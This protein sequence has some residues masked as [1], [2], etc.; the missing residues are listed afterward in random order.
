ML[1]AFIENLAQRLPISSERSTAPCY[2]QNFAESRAPTVATPS[3]P[4]SPHSQANKPEMR[5]TSDLLE[6]LQR[7]LSQ[8][9][10]AGF[11]SNLLTAPSASPS[12][13]RA[14]ELPKP[15]D[16][17]KPAQTT[18]QEKLFSV[19]VEIEQAVNLPKLNVSKKYGKRNK[20][21]AGGQQQRI[22][23]E[24]SA[25][26]TFEGYNL[27][28]GTA[29]TVKS[30]EG[31][32]YTTAVV[33][34]SCNPAWGK[35]FAVQLPV[36]LMTNDEKR[37]IL[38]VWRKAVSAGGDATKT[39]SQRGQQQPAPMEDAV[40]GFTAV[41]LS[42]LL[43]GMPCIMGW[44]NIMDFSGRCNGQIKVSHIQPQENV[45][46]TDDAHFRSAVDRRR[47]R[48]HRRTGNTSLSRAL[49]RKIYRTR[50]NLPRL[51]A[52]LF[53]VTGS[54]DNDDPDDEFERDLNTEAEEGDDG[55]WVDPLED[56]FSGQK[57]NSQHPNGEAA[58]TLTTNTSSY[59][60]TMNSDRRVPERSL[61]G[62]S[63]RSTQRS[64]TS[65]SVLEGQ[66]QLEELLKKH[67]LDTLINPK[68]LKSLINPSVMSTSE[69]TP[70]P[71]RGNPY[72][73]L[74]QE[75]TGSGAGTSAD[76]ADMS[77]DSPRTV[78][79]DKVKLISSALQRTTIS[80]DPTTVG[81]TTTT[82]TSTK[83]E[84]SGEDQQKREAPEG[85]P[86]KVNDK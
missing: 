39:Q 52:R 17:P 21:K 82:T 71:S 18:P 48:R 51:K 81:T 8:K 86:M 41:D 5:K 22:E 43:N 37:F 12:E 53:D 67:D 57:R 46:S 15:E 72:E 61:T 42:V 59:S 25:Y 63:D 23:L 7:A 31:I 54:D 33:E 1:S 2:D 55:E 80:D 58:M 74:L 60:Y 35:K 73:N 27:A 66:L 11:T 9:P 10:P 49:K 3:L 6:N 68:L 36:D 64:T 44:Y 32:V 78:T 38:K 77:E 34:A 70:S 24:P 40:V 45:T 19:A 79:S 29:N 16:E 13:E 4:Q 28:A 83:G 20:N 65:A 85:E 62:C 75:E 56:T 30:H 84:G 76:D 50:R 47:V 26:V 14:P 69:S